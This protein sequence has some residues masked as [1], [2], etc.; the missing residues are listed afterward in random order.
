VEP[1]IVTTPLGIYFA[2]V[3]AGDFE[4][5]VETFSEGCVYARPPVPT[6]E[7]PRRSGLEL[8]VGKDAVRA[9]LL[10]RGKL[11]LEHRIHSATIDSHQCFVRGTANFIGSS[12]ADGSVFIAYADL[13]GD[14]LISRFLALS[15]VVDAATAERIV[16]PAH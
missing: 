14:G 11:P 3:D 1:D 16:A 15:T 10:A 8:M 12:G 9:F 13:D 2:A 4:A 6:A 7:R 5:A